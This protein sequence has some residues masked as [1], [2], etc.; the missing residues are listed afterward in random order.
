[1]YSHRIASALLTS[2]IVKFMTMIPSRRGFSASGDFQPTG[3][4]TLPARVLGFRVQDLAV[5]V[6]P[7]VPNPE[8]SFGC[9]RAVLRDVHIDPRAI[10]TPP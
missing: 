2:N 5:D 6:K 8:P 4:N 10:E 9:G 3:R 1:M 7:R